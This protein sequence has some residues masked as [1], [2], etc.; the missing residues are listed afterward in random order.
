MNGLTL[1]KL[2]EQAELEIDAVQ[3][4]MQL[5]LIK[6]QPKAVSRH[7]FY[8]Q[9]EVSRLR[10]IKRA[11]KLGFSLNEIKE[12]LFLKSASH[13]TKKDIKN[14]TLINIKAVEN[15]ML[16][17]YRIKGA[18]EHL[19]STCDGHG[20]VCECQTLE[21]LDPDSQERLGWKHDHHDH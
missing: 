1:D 20:P 10:F 18:L 16:D 21:A 6:T 2:A 3:F 15:K 5:G 9:E 8:S 17:L 19:V 14:R 12:L 4:Y 11:Q 13:T 7:Q